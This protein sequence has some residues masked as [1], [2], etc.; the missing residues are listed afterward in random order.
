MQLQRLNCAAV[1]LQYADLRH[2]QNLTHLE[3]HA[4]YYPGEAKIAMWEL[5]QIL[6]RNR[7]LVHLDLE[8]MG[9][10]AVP[11]L[12]VVIAVSCPQLR[13]FRIYH[14]GANRNYADEVDRDRLPDATKSAERKVLKACL[15]LPEITWA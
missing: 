14:I 4:L 10:I 15:G 1:E 11:E 13:F 9:E 7:N 12:L 8:F 5:K 2:L 3:L 6:Q